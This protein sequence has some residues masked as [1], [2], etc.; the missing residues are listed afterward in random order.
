MP[1][2][3][4][5]LPLDK[6]FRMRR[7][8]TTAINAYA[9]VSGEILVD[10]T[11]NTAVLMSGT[12]GTNYP[13]AKESRLLVAGSGVSFSVAGSAVNQADLSS[14]IT[15]GIDASAL[16]AANDLLTVDSTTG[17]IKGDFSLAY[18]PVTGQ[19]SVLGSDDTTVLASVT[20][21]SHLSALTAATLEEA[22]TAVPVNGNTSGKFLHFVFTLSDS[23][24]S[25]MYINV[26]DLVDVYTAGDGLTLTNGE[27][28][29]DPGNGLEIDSNGKVAVKVKSG[30]SILV[31]DSNGLHIDATALATATGQTIVSADT[32]NVITASS[33]DG[34]AFL[35]VAAGNNLLVVNDDGELVV[36]NDMGTLS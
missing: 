19:F 22:T 35:K 31:N 21:P 25:D 34:G 24:T 30:E 12:A 17:K 27:F 20:V 29:V 9:G 14:D 26:T 15:I 3:Y 18:N 2:D 32:D 16:V 23:T 4:S 11:K 7:G 1:T 8:T 5:V 10:L 33:N 28:A 6:H 36:P 13:L